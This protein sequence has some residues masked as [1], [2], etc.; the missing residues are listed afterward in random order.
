MS[1]PA[2]EPR[3][4]RFEARVR[5]SFAAQTAM[6]T[7]GAHLASVAPGAV[8]ITFAHAEALTQQHGFIHGGV[9]GAVLD[10]ACGYAA[11]SLMDDDSAILTVEYKVNFLSAASGALFRADG[12]VIKPGRTLTVCEGSLFARGPSSQ[13]A[14][15]R[16]VATASATLI[17][18]R[19]S[20]LTG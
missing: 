3:S 10:S 9:L 18:V 16:L 2:F 14:E 1:L 8:S 17:S 20:G 7:F 19:D 12:R 15:D 13:S 5:E 4:A 6:R 11:Y